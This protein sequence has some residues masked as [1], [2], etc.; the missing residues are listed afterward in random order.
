MADDWQ[1]KLR[2]LHEQLLKD[3]NGSDAPTWRSANVRG[4]PSSAAVQTRPST[5]TR[6]P[7]ID[8]ILGIDFGTRFTKAAVFLPHINQRRVL[9][10]GTQNTRVV[11]SRLVLGDDDRLYSVT[12]G[13]RTR[14][15]I[16]IEYLKNRLPDPAAGAFGGS[17]AVGGLPLSR[18]IKP[19]CAFYLADILRRAESAARAAF[20]TELAHGRRINWLAN[21]G[22]P[23]KHF[24]SEV[25]R[26][27]QEV[28]AVAWNWRARTLTFPY[29]PSLRPSMKGRPPLRSSQ[30]TCRSK[31]RLSSLPRWSILPSTAIQ[32]Q[33]SIH[34][35][36]LAAVRW[37]VQFFG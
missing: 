17:L 10:L 21:V 13:S 23:T 26:V 37:T 7:A 30:K 18:L 19:A 36:I 33:V 27:F 14:P 15:K 31:L 8:A 12:C 16:I 6:T 28:S 2:K 1:E 25:L 11:A 5:Q 4:V 20:P 22:V 24:D 35:L 9:A 3:K 32:H 34:S 29:P